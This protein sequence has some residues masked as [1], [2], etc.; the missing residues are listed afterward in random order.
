[1]E[2]EESSHRFKVV[3]VG[4]ST[5]GKTSII[6]SHLN[7]TVA[8]TSTLGA[9]STRIETTVEDQTIVLNVWDTAGQESFRN[10]VP[11][12][13]KG[14]QAAV[15][16]FDQSNS[17][18]FDHTKEWYKYITDLVG[19]III[20]LAAN[21]SDLPCAV[22]F[23]EVYSWASEHNM[24]VITTSAL[25]GTNVDEVFGCVSRELFLK[26]V[27]N[28]AKSKEPEPEATAVKLEKEEENVQNETKSSKSGNCCK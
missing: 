4:D 7:Q 12:Y 2:S 11:I 8:S 23:N 14:A 21:K 15:I 27:K 24:N 20:C 5:V 22:D 18:S 28:D 6:Y 25:E 10:L 3:F 26:F 19:D 1:M 16:V 17:E 9:T 13:A